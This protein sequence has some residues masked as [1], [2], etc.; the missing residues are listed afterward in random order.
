MPEISCP[1][2]VTADSNKILLVRSFIDGGSPRALTRGEYYDHSFPL[3]A[4]YRS[5]FQLTDLA[6]D[7]WIYYQNVRGLR[8]KIDDVFLST[9]DCNFDIIM[10]T[11]TGLD[12]SI[13]SLQLFGNS[14]NVFRCDRSPLNSNKRSFGGTLIAVA[15]QHTS[16]VFET[17]HGSRL[18]QVCVR[19]TINGSKFLLCA[20]Y[21]PPDKSNDIAII[22]AHVASVR[23]LCESNS[24]ICSVLVCGDYNQPR[25]VWDDCNGAIQ[26]NDSTTI[27]PSSATLLD[28]MDY[29][30]LNQANSHSNHLGR[31]LDLVFHSVGSQVTVNE[32]I[33]PMLLVDVHHPPLTISMPINKPNMTVRSFGDNSKRELNYR[34]ID[35]AAFNDY[36]S[37]VDWPALLGTNNVNLMAETFCAVVRSWLSDHLPYIKRPSSPAWGTRS[38]RE[39][40]R[41][42]NAWQR[43]LRH[44][45]SAEA[46]REYKRSSSEYRRLNS[47][48]YK[49]YVLKVQTDLR[50]NPKA[51]WNFVNSKRK[52][53][54]IPADVYLDEVGAGSATDSCELFASFFSSVFASESVSN[55]HALRAAANVPADLIDLDIFVITPHMLH[56][57]ASKLKCSYSA[58][59]DGIP[60]VLLS[61]CAEV[62]A[63]PLCCIFN[64]SLVQCKFPDVWKHSFMFPVFKSGDRRNVRNYRG[65]T[66]LSAASKLFEIIVSAV[67]LNCAK[68]YIS[69][70]QHGFVPGRSVT[71]NLLDFTSNCIL[72]MERKAQVDVVYTDLKAAFDRIDH[73]ILLTKIARLGASRRF[74]TWLESFL[75]DRLLQVK[76][77]QCLSSSFTNKSG[78]PQGSN[79]GPLLFIIFFNDADIT[80][81]T[82]CRLVYADDFKMFLT[83]RNIEDCYRLQ[84]MLDSFVKWCQLN[85]LIISIGKCE[86]MTFHRIK[87]PIV[88]HYSI[89][90]QALQRVDHVNDLGVI[91][92]RKL[93]FDKHRNTIISKATRQL[94][95]IAKVGRGFTDPH[96]LKALYCSLVR[97]LL[98]NVSVIWTPHQLTWNLRIERVQRRFVRLALRDLPWRDPVNLPPY[99]DRCRLLGLDTLERRRKLQ[100]ALLIPKILNGEVDSPKLLSMIN[101]RA[102][103]RMLRPSSVLVN[104]FH[105]YNFAYHEPVASSVRVFTSVEQ[106]FD[107]GMPSHVFKRKIARSN[108]F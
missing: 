103:Q 77:N 83:I 95:F 31:V 84:L 81:G 102:T 101:L 87:S 17:V 78:V 48:L 88:F 69:S 36:I 30:N 94:G 73:R 58:G 89:D 79:L 21:I 106:L 72:E 8:T 65:I 2:A 28:G 6:S 51:F 11:E 70:Y 42:R 40:K 46:K 108:F 24:D 61:R 100:Q 74:V 7:V 60:P 71:T 76:L 64:Q 93:T 3:P 86:V 29:L 44:R 41:K 18:E 34:R 90:G 66:N 49:S 27:P 5:S 9:S 56:A 20:I 91:L 57:A 1:A 50:R 12:E 85:C 47:C 16:A 107:F 39:L 80:L 4:L 54:S 32:C 13:S 98:E 38:L 10:L 67:I 68:N 26:H 25:L 53:S 45:R 37:S 104:Q 33:A 96:C 19:A 82:G 43:L 105:R 23:D 59:P 35:F 97:P 62:L 15:Q 14:F 99:P 22:E 75:C 52:C 63:A 92:D 55:E